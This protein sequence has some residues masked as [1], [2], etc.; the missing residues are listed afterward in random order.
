MVCACS[1]FLLQGVK[2]APSPRALITDRYLP[3]SNYKQ[4]C[5]SVTLVIHTDQRRLGIWGGMAP[6]QRQAV[7]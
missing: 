2:C 4:L 7:S 3:L 6:G 5:L 1:D